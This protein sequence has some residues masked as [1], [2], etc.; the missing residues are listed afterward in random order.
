[1]LVGFFKFE[2]VLGFAL[3]GFLDFRKVLGYVYS[4]LA[5]YSKS[6]RFRFSRFSVFFQKLVGWGLVGFCT[7]LKNYA[8]KDYIFRDACKKKKSL[9]F[10]LLETGGGGGRSNQ[11]CLQKPKNERFFLQIWIKSRKKSLIFE[12]LKTK[13]GG[14]AICELSRE[15]KIWTIFF[16]QASLNQIKREC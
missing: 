1:M 14:A 12:V 3:V 6:T 7:F 10:C 9:I 5:F 13:G 2:K 4:V 15:D 8:V 16:L 11:N